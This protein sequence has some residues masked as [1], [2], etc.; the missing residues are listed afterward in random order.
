[1]AIQNN[2]IQ[3][4]ELLLKYKINMDVID[5]NG[6]SPIE[7]ALNIFIGDKNIRQIILLLN[8]CKYTRNP[9]WWDHINSFGI[10]NVN[11][12]NDYD[13]CIYQDIN[14][15]KILMIQQLNDC[16]LHNLVKF[17]MITEIRYFIKHNIN[18]L[19]IKFKYLHKELYYL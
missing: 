7:Y 18:F 3:Y 17:R 19:N 10:Y 16:I 14:N 12:K 15:E 8:S 13:K 1:M 5:E 9:K 6:Y 11:P 4:I 2:K